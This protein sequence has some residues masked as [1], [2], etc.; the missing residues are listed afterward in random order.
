M[1]DISEQRLVSVLTTLTGLIKAYG[2]DYWP[3][4]DRLERELNSVRERKTKLEK[5]Q[6]PRNQ[7]SGTSSIN[8]ITE[9][10][11]GP[12]SSAPLSTKKY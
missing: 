1:K 4:F 10:T 11:H 7:P 3:I 6:S 12:K 9:K 8:A 5:Y 2:D